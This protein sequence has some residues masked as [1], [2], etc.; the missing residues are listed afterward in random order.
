MLRFDV[1]VVLHMSEEKMEGERGDTCANRWLSARKACCAL[2][3][4]WT[5]SHGSVSSSTG[6]FFP[7]TYVHPHIPYERNPFGCGF[8]G[9]YFR[10]PSEHEPS[11]LKIVSS[12]TSTEFTLHTRLTSAE[13]NWV[14]WAISAARFPLAIVKWWCLGYQ[15]GFCKFPW[16]LTK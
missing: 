14:S 9:M 2:G 13:R 5:V 6:C 7:S 8:L 1:G 3:L 12:V 11:H 4:C 15:L 16:N 10:N